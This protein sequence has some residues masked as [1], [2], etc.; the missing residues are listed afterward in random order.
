RRRLGPRRDAPDPHAGGPRLAAYEL[1]DQL[2]PEAAQQ[3]E[4]GEPL[5]EVDVHHVPEDRA[6]AD[7]DQGLGNRLG[8]LAQPGPR[9]ATKDRHR[10]KHRRIIHQARLGYRPPLWGAISQW[11]A[12]PPV[13]ASVRGPDTD[14]RA[15]P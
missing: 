6:S 12:Q 4:L 9:A 13:T 11:S 5:R 10:R 8:V 14:Y 1:L 3:H 7:L 15:V 2:R